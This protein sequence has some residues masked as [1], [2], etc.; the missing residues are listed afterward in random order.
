MQTINMPKEVLSMK[1][2]PVKGSIPIVLAIFLTGCCCGGGKETV[3]VPPVDDS[4]TVGQ[5]LQDLKAAHEQGAMTDEEYEKQ[6]EN[7]L[8]AK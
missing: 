1:R 3:I 5:Q 8:K 2:N 6:K 4:A 7:V